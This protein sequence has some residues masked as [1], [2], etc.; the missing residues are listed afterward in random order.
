MFVVESMKVKMYTTII[1]P[2]VFHGCE[3]SS[4][5]LRE[6]HR[7]QGQKRRF[8]PKREDEDLHDI[9]VSPDVN[10]GHQMMDD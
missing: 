3:T 10:L 2:L 1:L 7:L 8:G 9:Y 4:V 6:Q 5:M